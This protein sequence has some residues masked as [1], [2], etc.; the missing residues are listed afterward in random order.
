MHFLQTSAKNC[1]KTQN[2]F[3]LI[4][5]YDKQ[6]KLELSGAKLRTVHCEHNL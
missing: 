2:S 4:I 6:F 5:E 1:E 3:S